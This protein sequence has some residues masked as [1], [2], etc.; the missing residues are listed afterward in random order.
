L[1]PEID[2]I[3]VEPREDTRPIHLLGDHCSTRIGTSLSQE[4]AKRISKML[5]ANTDTFA[6]TVTDMSGFSPTIIVH[7]L[8]MYKE[9]KP[10]AQKMRKLGDEKRNDNKGESR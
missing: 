8:S 1:D 4:D 2:D 6:W 9:V 7:K 10:V 5:I 3:S